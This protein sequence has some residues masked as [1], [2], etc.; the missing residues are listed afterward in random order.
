MLRGC[1]VPCPVL[2]FLSLHLSPQDAPMV[3]YTFTTQFMIRH[4]GTEKLTQPGLVGDGE[5][6]FQN[7][8]QTWG[9]KFVTAV[10][11]ALHASWWSREDAVASRRKLVAQAPSLV[12]ELIAEA[13]LWSPLHTSLIAFL[14]PRTFLRD[15]DP[16]DNPFLWEGSTFSFWFELRNNCGCLP[17]P[18]EVVLMEIWS[19]PL[20]GPLLFTLFP[21]VQH[22]TWVTVAC[23][24]SVNGRTNHKSKNNFLKSICIQEFSAQLHIFSPYQKKKKKSKSAA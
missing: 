1:S 24:E 13:G 8:S 19:L 15:H 7:S 2:L 17:P 21:L 14:E 6:G 11:P 23:S 18:K 5:W 12:E 10:H 22:R 3:V 16:S 4:G 9:L 20:C